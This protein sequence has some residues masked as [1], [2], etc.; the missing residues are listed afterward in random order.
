MPADL[1]KLIGK[2]CN[3]KRKIAE[4]ALERFNTDFG[5]DLVLDDF[6]AM[7][8]RIVE[9]GSSPLAGYREPFTSR[10][11]SD[12]LEHAVLLAFGEAL[13]HL[14]PEHIE[15]T[16]I[17]AVKGLI[18]L[19]SEF[20]GS[21]KKLGTRVEKGLLGQKGELAVAWGPVLGGLTPRWVTAWLGGLDQAEAVIDQEIATLSVKA[22]VEASPRS[23]GRIASSRGVFANLLQDA[24]Q[25]HP[26]VKP[27]QITR[28]IALLWIASGW[29]EVTRASFNPRRSMDTKVV[30]AAV[31]DA[32]DVQRPM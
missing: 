21:R 16:R 22:D 5:A 14:V 15:R 23:S 13:G 4:A 6:A 32:L 19:K 25:M 10:H 28:A 2:G 1:D 3:F 12:S 20:Q 11:P 9:L 18:A 17:E 7:A 31:R 8:A 29:Y 26:S 24:F 30:V 27:R